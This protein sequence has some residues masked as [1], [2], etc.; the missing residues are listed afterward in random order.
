MAKLLNIVLIKPNAWNPNRMDDE[1]FDNLVADIRAHGIGAID[2]IHVRPLDG[3]FEC[4]DGEHRLRA[5]KKAGFTK[6]GCE[7]HEVDESEAKVMNYRKNKE[8]GNL[9][10]FKEA[11]LFKSELE[12]GLTQQQIAERY[13]VSQPQ[14]SAR[15]SLLRISGET[16]EVITRVISPRYELPPSHLESI[17]TLKPKQ[18]QKLTK[19]IVREYKHEPPPVRTIER[20]V[21]WIKREER[22]AEELRKAVEKAKF[23]KCPTC[24]K[25]ARKHSWQRLPWVHCDNYHEWSLE[26]G[27]P[28]REPI[29]RRA[30]KGKPQLPKYIRSTHTIDDFRNVFGE[31]ARSLVPKI[32]EINDLSCWGEEDHVHADLRG[33]VVSLGVNISGKEFSLQVEPKSYTTKALQQFKTSVSMWP[34][35]RTKKDLAKL[36]QLVSQIFKEFGGKVHG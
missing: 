18:Q 19:E 30:E 1:T 23:P 33:S 34:E 26:T 36:E 3:G 20:K 16:K 4:I 10:Y 28:K 6:I 11:E 17:A 25:P 7:I 24:G 9:D 29:V 13:G 35:P 14:V 27:A 31:Y 15:L 12:R 8:R 5:V 21:S 22:E 2:P 32:K